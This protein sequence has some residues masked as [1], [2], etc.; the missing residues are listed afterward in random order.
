MPRR[1]LAQIGGDQWHA[2]QQGL[3]D[4]GRRLSQGRGRG[5]EHKGV[6]VVS[7]QGEQ[8]TLE[9]GGKRQTLRVGDAPAS[10][11]AVRA[12]NSAARAWC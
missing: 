2:G 5:R 6:K 4:C 9:M 1:L 10:V 11:G 3:A 12:P 8:V 7:I